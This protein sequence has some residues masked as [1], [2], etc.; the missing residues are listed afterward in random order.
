[1]NSSQLKYKEQINKMVFKG[2]KW[3]KWIKINNK[4]FNNKKII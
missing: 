1:M 3:N 2:Y 4:L